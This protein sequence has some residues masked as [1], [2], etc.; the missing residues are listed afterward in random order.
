MGVGFPARN[1]GRFEKTTVEPV[2]LLLE[3]S[4]NGC[5]PRTPP[6]DATCRTKV[7]VCRVE[8]YM[9]ST[10]REITLDAGTFVVGVPRKVN[11]ST[12]SQSGAPDTTNFRYSSSREACTVNANGCPTTAAAF[13]RDAKVFDAAEYVPERR[14]GNPAC[15]PR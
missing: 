5:C 4:T 14:V 8:S 6:E 15:S 2:Y 7:L 3:T 10:T 11:P 13:V 9:S 12:P 1:G